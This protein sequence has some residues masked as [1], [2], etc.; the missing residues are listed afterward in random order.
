MMG[1]NL[2]NHNGGAQSHQQDH[3]PGL[4]SAM[5]NA[6][7]KRLSNP[8]VPGW[9]RQKD[10][11][12]DFRWFKE[13]AERDIKTIIGKVPHFAEL[14]A[15]T[16]FDIMPRGADAVQAGFGNRPMRRKTVQGQH[17]SE[18]GAHIV[19][20]L[21]PTGD[22]ATILYPAKSDVA[23]VH[24]EMIFLRIGRI[25]GIPLYDRLTHDLRYLVAYERVTSL[26]TSPSVRERTM[27]GWLRVW[28]KMQV[29]GKTT[30]PRA[31]KLIKISTTRFIGALLGAV[32]KPVAVLIVAYLLLRFGMPDMA[33]RLFPHR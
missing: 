10:A 26:D 4:G 24:E 3:R 12:H 27:V 25:G 1:M 7:G 22:V 33:E 11:E 9:R 32:L 15:Y 18:S 30:S 17:A 20:S 6:D 23:S 5:T 19:Y 16:G 13:R 8:F 31:N 28:N 2:G 14:D 29:D 21:G